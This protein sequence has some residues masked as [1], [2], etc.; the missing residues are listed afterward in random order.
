MATTHLRKHCASPSLKPAS[1][2]SAGAAGQ[3]VRG[4]CAVGVR[5][6]RIVCEDERARWARRGAA[7]R[8]VAW[9]RTSV[10]SMKASASR[11]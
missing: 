4:T 1:C 3:S 9:R 11:M 8:G 10:I 5:S 6:D 7:R 2:A